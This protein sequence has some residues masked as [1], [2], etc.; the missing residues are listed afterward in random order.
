MMRS[1]FSGVSSLRVHQ[2]RMDVIANNISNVNTVGFKGQRATF[3]D[4]FYQRIRGATPPDPATGR[5]GTNAQQIGLG[6]NLNS[7]DNIMTQGASQR[8]DNPFDL[9]IQGSGFF[10]VDTGAGHAYTRAGNISLDRD[11][12]MHINGMQLLGWDTRFENGVHVVDRSQL[13]PLAISGDKRNMP[14]EPTTFMNIIASLDRDQMDG[15]GPPPFITRTMNFYDSI[16]TNWQADVRF[17]FHAEQS[18]AAQ[19]PHSY[20][21]FEFM[22]GAGDPPGTVRIFREGVRDDPEAVAT[23]IMNANGSMSNANSI[24]GFRNEAAASNGRRGTIAF[25]TNGDFLGVGNVRVENGAFLPI[26][27]IGNNQSELPPAPGA[28]PAWFIP[29]EDNPWRMQIVPNAD[30]N[31]AA[32]FGAMDDNVF[33]YADPAGSVINLASI[34]TITF[35]TDRLFA[36]AGGTQARIDAVD[37]NRA[38]DLV[39]VSVGNDGTIMGRYSNGALRVLGQIPLARFGNQEGLDRAGANLWL[40]SANSGE[41]E[42]VIGSMQGGALEMS[43]VDLAAEFTEMIT[44]QRGF[45]AASRTISTSDEM[46]QE[47]VN[48]RR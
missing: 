33:F 44:T 26:Q 25:D 23:V 3:Q 12:N 24:D 13:V 20:W 4:A 41:I 32:S 45:Q 15:E 21:T 28:G 47:L 30:V 8:T 6:I 7:I 37:G 22:S 11:F 27:F 18:S 9:A 35:N 40:H 43:N 14:A 17:F 10:I 31:P 19:S 39:D 46:L 2:S 34:G 29:N 36:R 1:L 16:G 42:I 48:L 5:T 38:G